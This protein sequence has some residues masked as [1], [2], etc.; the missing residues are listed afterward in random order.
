MCIRKHKS[1]QRTTPI[2]K[3]NKTYTGH[4]KGKRML[5]EHAHAEHKP[6]RSKNNERSEANREGAAREQ[7]PSAQNGLTLN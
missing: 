3:T 2:K 1:N 4:R 5:K 7:K 6:V